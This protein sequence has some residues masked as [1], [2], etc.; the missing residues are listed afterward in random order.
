MRL[1]FKN[2]LRKFLREG[3]LF[4]LKTPTQTLVLAEH[5]GRVLIGR[6]GAVWRDITEYIPEVETC[7]K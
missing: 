3:D 5:E 4:W 7:Q 2:L 1:K 6:D